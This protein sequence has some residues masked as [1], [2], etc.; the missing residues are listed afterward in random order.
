[1]STSERKSSVSALQNSIGTIALDVGDVKLVKAE[2]QKQGPCLICFQDSV[3][4][5][6]IEFQ[7]HQI[8]Q[9]CFTDYLKTEIVSAKVP[10][11]IREQNDPKL[12][13]LFDP[14]GRRN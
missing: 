7:T 10:P 14:I 6:E 9:D 12:T 1:M 13:P 8:C 2:P 4:L 3:K 11:F 5:L